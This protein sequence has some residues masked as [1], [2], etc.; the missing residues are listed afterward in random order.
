MQ[1]GFYNDIAG[2]GNYLGEGQ[3]TKLKMK[4]ILDSMKTMTPD[5]MKNYLISNPELSK[6]FN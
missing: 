4:M 3:N 2:L 5:V 1:N 6:Y